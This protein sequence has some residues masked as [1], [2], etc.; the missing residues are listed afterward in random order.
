VLS[1]RLVVKKSAQAVAGGQTP[2]RAVYRHRNASVYRI[3]DSITSKDLCVF[4]DNGI[5]DCV[6]MCLCLL[7]VKMISGWSVAVAIQDSIY[8]SICE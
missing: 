2:P 1:E 3:A 7:Y 6:I 8:L 5:F 4:Y